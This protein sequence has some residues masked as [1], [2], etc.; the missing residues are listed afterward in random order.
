[1][2]AGLL[3]FFVM[4]WV[5]GAFLGSTFEYHDST[6]WSG[7][8]TGGYTRSPMTTLEFLKDIRN[9]TQQTEILG[10]IPMIAPNSEY[11]S[12]IFDI[13]LWRFSFLYDTDGEF[14]YGLVYYIFLFPFV[15]MGIIS[16]VMLFIGVLRGNLTF[17]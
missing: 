13:V 4:V 11:F 5:I 9:V 8:G 2:R 12:A 1:M 14:A 6:T 15:L 7:N 17:T 3:A 10:A 16:L